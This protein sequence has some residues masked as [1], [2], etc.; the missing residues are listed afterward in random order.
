MK[1]GVKHGNLRL[2]RSKKSA[3]R[4]DALSAAG[5]VQRRK[6]DAPLDFCEHSIV[7]QDRFR[8]LFTAVHDPMSHRI[9]IASTLRLLQDVIKC[10]GAKMSH[11]PTAE[12][13]IP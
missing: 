10:L 13:F 11:L 1:R 6:F 5:I 3:R 9:D 2:S 4:A 7:D 8:K 12:T